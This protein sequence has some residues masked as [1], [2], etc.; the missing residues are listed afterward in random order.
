MYTVRGSCFS[1]NLKW[2]HNTFHDLGNYT[3]QIK[4]QYIIIYIVSILTVIYHWVS[5]LYYLEFVGCS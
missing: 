3:M 5:F 4:L 2:Q 1:N